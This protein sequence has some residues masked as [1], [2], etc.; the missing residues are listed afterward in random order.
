M[1]I[2]GDNSLI[3]SSLEINKEEPLYTQIE[4]HIIKSIEK[5]EL[6][7]GS[8]LPSTREVSE[9]LNI[10]RNTIVTAYEDLESQ[11][12]VLSEKGKGTFVAREAKIAKDDYNIHWEDKINNYGKTCEALDVVKRELPWKKGMISF[13]S[14][15]PE[16]KLFDLEEFK[17]SFL[18]AWSLEG[19]KLL[20][21]GY[22]K[23]Y[24]PL[25]EYLLQYMKDKGVNTE[26]KDILITNGFTEGFDIILGALTNAKDII[27]CEEPTHNTALKIMKAYGLEILSVPMDEG[28]IN[29]AQLEKALKEESPK[30]AYLIPSYHNPTGIVMKGE[31]R[32]KVYNLFKKHSVPII[33]DGF[34]EELLYSSSPIE[35]MAA[36]ASRG[37]GVVYIGSFSKILFPGLRIGWILADKTLIDTLESVKRA[38]TIHCSFLDQGVFYHYM[39]S[40]AFNK[41]L[42]KAR[43]IYKNKYNFTIQQVKEHIP[44]EFIMGEGG[45]HVF[46]KLKRGINSREV[47][48]LCYERGVLFTPGDIFYNNNKEISTLRLGFS[49]LSE[50]DIKKGIKIIG[51][52]VRSLE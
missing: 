42:K 15:A 14:I 20:N 6:K 16:E 43:K 33:E 41:Y 28:G 34:N 21:Y 2:R 46:L 10:S 18:E 36:L 9:L 29:I 1:L 19:E 50:E 17:R 45:L 38:K 3:F 22:A 52:V 48:R 7:K 24:K 27:L 51:E 12:I 13:K 32:R 37:N 49:R 26:G 31:R 35:P 5:G 8:K 11:G 39:K 4:K 25:I 40:G 30:L 44:H 23:G 47:L